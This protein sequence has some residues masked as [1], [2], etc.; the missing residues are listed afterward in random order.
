M[1]SSTPS[2]H[3]G[4]T[5]SEQELTIAVWDALAQYTPVRV[6]NDAVRVNAQAGTIALSG[7]VRSRT[8]KEKAEEIA[9]QVKGVSAVENHLVVDADVELAVAQALG[10]DPRTKAAFPG[11]LVGV[12]FG[13]VYLKGQV[14]TAEVKK[15]ASE[16]ALK[17]AG[18]RS[19]SNELTAPPEPVAAAK[20]AAPKPQPAGQV[21]A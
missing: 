6:W 5:E 7:S 2:I 15:A 10:A 13:V 20:P 19:V 4:P 16:V 14:A 8:M 18:V 11:V 21:A 1:S 3:D 17:V 9:R 12:V